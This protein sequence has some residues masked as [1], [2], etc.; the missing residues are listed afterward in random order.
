MRSILKK[1]VQDAAASDSGELQLGAHSV[2]VL[3]FRE[4]T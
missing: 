2:G 4:L 3:A 1:C